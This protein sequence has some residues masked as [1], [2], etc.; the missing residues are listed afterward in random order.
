MARASRRM[1]ILSVA[2]VGTVLLATFW[3]NPGSRGPKKAV[4]APAVDALAAVE[5]L[6]KALQVD[7]STQPMRNPF[8]NPATESLSPVAGVE[9]TPQRGERPE[10]EM[11]GWV[12]L[13]GIDYGLVIFEGGESYVKAGD[14]VAGWRVLQV[15]AQGIDLVKGQERE[16]VSLKGQFSVIPLDN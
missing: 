1:A 11:R 10:V 16:S 2:L 3:R 13:N 14:E 15:S 5:R 9:P 12:S 4:P 7:Q 8:L 6:T